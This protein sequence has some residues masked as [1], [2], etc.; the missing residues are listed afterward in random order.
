MKTDRQVRRK[1]EI[2]AAAYEVLA[3]KGYKATSMLAIAKRAAASNET[4]YNWYGNKQTLFRSMVASNA[5]QA[6]RLLENFQDGSTETLEAI[7]KL[8]PVLLRI[9]TG[10]KAIALNRA[11]AGDVHETGL[12]GPTIAEAGKGTIAPMLTDA[13][14]QARTKGLLAFDDDEDVAQIYISLLIADLQIER[15]IGVRDAPGD[16]E[17]EA[18]AER[19]WRLLYRLFGPEPS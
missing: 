11:A 2:E 3:E 9:V 1:R 5:L 12:L 15:V 10:E 14:R 18:R 19:A 13:F 16:A 8:G 17:I 4:L 6:E 7:R